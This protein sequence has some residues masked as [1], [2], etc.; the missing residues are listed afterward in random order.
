MFDSGDSVVVAV[1]GGPDSVCMLLVLHELS[2]SL[3][4]RLVVACLDHST[5]GGESQRDAAFVQ[6]LADSMQ[7][8]CHVD[9][10]EIGALKPPGVSFE[11]AARDAR[12]EFLERV[13]EETRSTKVAVGHTA[14]DQAETMLM[15]LLSGTGL[16]GLAGIR[17]VRQLGGVLLVRPLIDVKRSEIM[18]Y[19]ECHN[20]SF[21]VDETNLDPGYVRN[22]VRLELIPTLEKQY[23]RNVVDALTRAARVLQEEEEYLSQRARETAARV[24]SHENSSTIEMSRAAY[25][26][27]SPP[28]RRRLIMDVVRKLSAGMPRLTLASIQ[29]ADELCVDGRTGSRMSIWDDVELTVESER[30][31]VRKLPVDSCEHPIDSVVSVPVPGRVTASELGIDVE[32][33][34]FERTQT[35]RD[36]VAQCGPTFQLFDAEKVRGDL[37]VRT[38]LP[39]DRFYPLGLGGAKKLGDYFTD[40]KYSRDKRRRTALLLSGEDIMWIVGGAVDERFKL[41]DQTRR[42]LEVR[43]A[44]INQIDR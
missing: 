19:L 12:Y 41:T 29:S 39:G 22:K 36:L 44:Q 42:V 26:A 38:K 8:E 25:S 14:N 1:S 10:V 23:N 2:T 35:V 34:I 5:R 3:S 21:R 40:A 27:A 32:T 16:R 11:A 20:V 6:S 24:V 4:L 18:G 17:P 7:I 28:L 30:L 43:C 31:L 37:S 15:R 9:K 13:A 33:R